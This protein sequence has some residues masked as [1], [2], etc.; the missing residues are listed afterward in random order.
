M[1]TMETV[2][3]IVLRCC[4]PGPMP[5]EAR[6]EAQ[7]LGNHVQKSARALADKYNK[8]YGSIMLAAG[9]TIQNSRN[10]NFSNQFKTWY[11]VKYLKS[12]ECTWSFVYLLFIVEFT[13]IL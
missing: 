5:A 7:A 10:Q 12:P 3:K 6:T 4:T 1:R 2:T 9:L 8:P 13:C 11:S